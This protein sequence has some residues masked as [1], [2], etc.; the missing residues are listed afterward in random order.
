MKRMKTA[1]LLTL[2]TA[3]SFPAQQARAYDANP[4]AAAEEMARFFSLFCLERFPDKDA[5][6]TLAK[7]MKFKGMNYGELKRY[8]KDTLGAGWYY[9]ADSTLYVITVENSPQDSCSVRHMTP[10]GIPSAY[11]YTETLKN[12]ASAKK[13]KL[14]K[15]LVNAQKTADGS[16]VRSYSNFMEDSAGKQRELFMLVL[17]DYHGKVPQ[18]WIDDAQKQRG[19]EI[20]MERRLMGEGDP[21]KSSQ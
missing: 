10:E 13:G 8:Q 4:Q 3:I 16:D 11:S 1:I 6:D 21:Q 20:R 9:T 17:T 12:F 19:V 7:Q 15:A 5:M 14:F 18:E 2:L